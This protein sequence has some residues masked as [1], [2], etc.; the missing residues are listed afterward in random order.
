MKIL[1]TLVELIGKKS[2]L[3]PLTDS[4]DAWNQLEHHSPSY[5]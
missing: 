5:Q 1:S 4:T 2:Q 3:N